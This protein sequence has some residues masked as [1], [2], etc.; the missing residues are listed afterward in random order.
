MPHTEATLVLDKRFTVSDVPAR[1]FGSFVEQAG[2][3]VYHGLYEP[4]H[5]TADASGFRRDVLELVKELGVT[6]V[7]YPG[8]NYVSGHRWE[9]G[10]GPREARPAR[11]ELAWHGTEPNTFGLDEFSAWVTAAEVEPMLAVN[12]G[13]RGVLD[14]LDM[15][16]YCNGVGGTYQ[17]DRR[18]ANGFSAPFGVKIWCLGNEPDG[19]WQLGHT[20]ALHY[21]RLARQTASGMRMIDPSLE[22]VVAGSSGTEMPTYG[23]WE[24]VVLEE[25][26]D[27]VDYISAHQYYYE[28]DGDLTGYL[29]AAVDFDSYL[30]SVIATVDHV[31]SVRRSSRQVDVSVD[32]WGVWYQPDHRDEVAPHQWPVGGPRLE[33]H[34]STA[35]AVVYGSM[36]I[37]LLKRVDRVRAAS[38]AQLVNVIAPIM[39]EDGGGVWKQTIFHPFAAVA[40][41]IGAVVLQ[42][43]LTTAS[44][45]TKRFGT[46][47]VI[48]AV[49][50]LDDDAGIVTVFAINRSVDTSTTLDIDLH[51]LGAVRSAKATSLSD[52]DP[53]RK[54]N[55]LETDPKP[56]PLE[57]ALRSAGVGTELPPASWNVIEIQLGA[58]R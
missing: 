37:S 30:H 22:L 3:G 4:T 28:T 9:D 2:R 36:L 11:L 23:T 38:A 54:G 34:Y 15:L 8:G 42:P 19:P 51:T 57:V 45:T 1:L 53:R 13:T 50:V 44:M 52:S 6:T 58:D 25:T 33:E 46:V 55:G 49:G 27:D 32:E 18:R 16:E 43:A 10:T 12:L 47:P 48:D 5:P 56:Q 21:G 17:A 29:A 7:R 20:D 14:A 31:K 26:Y 39:T 24:R 40:R 35:D 41:T